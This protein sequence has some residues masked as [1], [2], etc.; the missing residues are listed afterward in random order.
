MTINVASRFLVEA[1]IAHKENVNSSPSDE[2]IADLFKKNEHQ[3][4]KR[5]GKII[6]DANN[7]NSK[8]NKFKESFSGASLFAIVK[9]FSEI[10]VVKEMEEN[11]DVSDL[12]A[13]L[14]LLVNG[15]AEYYQSKY[16]EKPMNKI[17]RVSQREGILNFKTLLR[18]I[19]SIIFLRYINDKD[20]LS[21]YP[22]TERIVDGL[23]NKSITS[24][25]F[26]VADNILVSLND[27]PNASE[28]TVSFKK[29][30]NL[31]LR[32]GGAEGIQTLIHHMIAGTQGIVNLLCTFTGWEENYSRKRLSQLIK[33]SGNQV[34]KNW[35]GLLPW[36]IDKMYH[37]L[38]VSG[39]SK[40]KAACFIH[41]IF[42][43]VI[44]DFSSWDVYNIRH[45]ER[46]YYE[47]RQSQLREVLKYARLK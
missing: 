41:N 45:P 7:Q 4:V 42:E 24:E 40:T 15:Y 27:V 31:F 38:R 37:E 11:G 12:T 39:I 28:V 35:H 9:W 43:P 23:N 5:V 25:L 21:N 20:V 1:F 46:T 29:N 8:V 13:E 26:T 2:S 33:Y 14:Q 18:D 10:M 3:E 47:Y 44:P 30:P 19:E 32:L 22:E 36:M 6:Q 16:S 34:K 17:E